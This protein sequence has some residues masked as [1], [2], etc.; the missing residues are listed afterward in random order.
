MAHQHLT[1]S[2]REMIAHLVAA[3]ES[4]REIART[5]ARSPSTISRELRRNRQRSGFYSPHLAQQ[6]CRLRRGLANEGRGGRLE[7]AALRRYVVDRLR[8]YWSPEQISGRLPVDYPDDSTMRVSH[9][10]IYAGIARD[11]DRGGQLWKRLRHSRKRRRRYGG[12]DHRGRI[13]NRRGLELRP[14][15]VSERTRLGD[16]EGDTVAGR[17][18]RGYLLTQVERKSRY[19]VAR[20]IPNRTSAEVNQA[21]RNSIR[22][23]PIWLR[24]TLTLDNGIEFAGHAELSVLGFDV[25]FADPYSAWQR[26][27]NENT[28]GLLRQFFPKTIELTQI[29]DKQVARATRLLN[30][31]PRKCLNYRTPRE[32]LNDLTEDP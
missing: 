31:R 14:A 2:E 9:E 8:R 5:L 23:I 28:N 11:K 20:R 30:T 21:I 17:G 6:Q 1:L 25:Y 10:T 29:T 3:G 24:R 27:T 18:G 19:V 16:W 32:V 7:N 15:V 4:L 26:G 22:H 13:R 12:R